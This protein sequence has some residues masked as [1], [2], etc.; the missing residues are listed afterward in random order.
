M[1]SPQHL[2][3]AKA[4]SKGRGRAVRQM[5]G[6]TRDMLIAVVGD[7][8]AG[9]GRCG[10]GDSARLGRFRG[11][12]FRRRLDG[13]VLSS[14]GAARKGAKEISKVTTAVQ[15]VPPRSP[16]DPCFSLSRC[17]PPRTYCLQHSEDDWLPGRRRSMARSG[18]GRHGDA[19]AKRYHRGPVSIDDSS[20]LP[21]IAVPIVRSRTGCQWMLDAGCRA[22]FGSGTS[23]EPAGHPERHRG[24]IIRHI[25]TDGTIRRRVCERWAS[26]S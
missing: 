3:G 7:G 9:R 20:G 1:Q 23:S 15:R 14:G 2:G 10:A 17:K 21:F 12:G 22:D 4:A 11:S 5:R 19:R 13:R 6:L 16:S 26:G 18:R 25:W 8:E 24:P